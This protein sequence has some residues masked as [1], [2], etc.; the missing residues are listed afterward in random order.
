M[1]LSGNTP[2]SWAKWSESSGDST[3]SPIYDGLLDA[4]ASERQALRPVNPEKTRE[5]VETDFELARC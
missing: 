1:R 2:W 4:L 3:D 5:P